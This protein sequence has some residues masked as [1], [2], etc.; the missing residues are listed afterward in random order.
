MPNRLTS[1]KDY[2]K[3]TRLNYSYK[4][5]LLNCVFELADDQGIAIFSDVVNYFRQFYV[6][7][8]VTHGSAD[9]PGARVNSINDISD[10]G[11]KTLIAENPLNA[12]AND[13]WLSQEGGSIRISASLWSLLK[14]P[15]KLDLM[16]DLN[17][18]IAA[19]YDVPSTPLRTIMIDIMSNYGA[20]AQRQF[21]GSDPMFKRLTVD[22]P[23]QLRSTGL[24]NHEYEVTGSAGQGNWATLPWAAVLNK[25]E[26]SSIQSGVYIV[27]CFNVELQASYLMLMQGVSKIINEHGSRLG[28]AKLRENASLIREKVKTNS[29]SYD[30][31]DLGTRGRAKEYDAGTIY[32]IRYTLDDLPSE[33]V[34]L[35]DFKTMLDVYKSY[36]DT[37]GG[38]VAVQTRDSLGKE[39][40]LEIHKYIAAKGFLFSY[41]DLANFYLALRTKPFV[42][43][44]GISGTGKSQLPQLFAESIGA[45]SVLVAVRP[46]WNDGSDLVGYVDLEGKFRPG[47]LTTLI[48]E[49]TDTPDT[50]VFVVLDE[51]N[52]ARVEHYL[53]DFLSVIETREKLPEGIWSKAILE[54]TLLPRSDD[55]MAYAS[56]RIP[57]NLYL[58]GT[59]NMDET[60]H[61]FSKKVLDRANTIEF[62]EIDLMGYKN[63]SAASAQPLQATSHEI[64]GQ[65]I[66]LNHITGNHES[67]IQDLV[68]KLVVVNSL[69]E[70]AG[71]HVGYRVRDEISIYMVHNKELALLPEHA[72]FDYQIMQKILP[73]I[74]GST[75]SIRTLLMSLLKFAGGI[76]LQ[77][78]NDDLSKELAKVQKL[79][80]YQPY[81]KSAKKIVSMLR[82]F[83][84]DGFTSYWV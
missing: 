20:T 62:S 52:L 36:L 39:G 40:L 81:P 8:I 13:G 56:L 44:A 84:E 82:R 21:A 17:Q 46:D 58:V 78:H 67:L 50:P 6:D 59:V 9:K 61:P 7:R 55:A 34:L 47:R 27:Y 15:D 29:L 24:N 65:Y 33:E 3:T 14:T 53:A 26:T 66:R 79:N 49:C 60:T 69:L 25:S 77:A 68:G 71:L 83:E 1:F 22:L 42:I 32:Y 23:T 37:R 28:L 2:I 35:N 48:Q 18:V 16:H 73:R 70:V 74:Q 12:L 51:M 72:A 63:S 19:Y 4:L 5:V 11:L 38:V 30:G 31:I 10:A 54:N 75:Q 76:D 57:P 43:L 80:E 64:A 41:D 45:R